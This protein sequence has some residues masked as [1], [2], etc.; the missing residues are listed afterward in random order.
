MRWV[1]NMWHLA[2]DLEK[3]PLGALFLMADLN[4]K[5]LIVAD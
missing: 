4:K 3:H 5:G 2:L 1:C